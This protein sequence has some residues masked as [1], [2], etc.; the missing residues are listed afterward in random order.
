MTPLNHPRKDEGPDARQ[1]S[2]PSGTATTQHTNC[3]PAEPNAQ[4]VFGAS[5]APMAGPIAAQ[6]A[7]DLADAIGRGEV[8]M[9]EVN[10]N[11][12]F[13]ASDKVL[14]GLVGGS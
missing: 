1:R 6:S 9:L 5:S 8:D 7:V 4:A 13:F 2:E 12:M 14:E 10:G 3:P 11:A